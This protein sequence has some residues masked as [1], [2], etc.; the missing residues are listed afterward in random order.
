VPTLIDADEFVQVQ[1]YDYLKLG[2]LYKEHSSDEPIVALIDCSFTKTALDTIEQANMPVKI[3]KDDAE[4]EQDA[5]YNDIIQFLEDLE[6]DTEMEL[7]TTQ[8]IF[9]RKMEVYLI[10]P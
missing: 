10:N 6:P 1:Y 8:V 3:E 9:E 4:Q 5:F 7:L 2:E